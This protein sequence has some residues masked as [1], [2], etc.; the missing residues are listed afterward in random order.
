MTYGVWLTGML[1][2]AAV[3]ATGHVKTT[4]KRVDK[5]MAGIAANVREPLTPEVEAWLRPAL[6]ARDRWTGLVGLAGAMLGGVYLT[7]GEDT[8]A[9]WYVFMVLLGGTAG[10]VVGALVAG[11]RT[12]PNPDSSL[13][14]ASPRDRRLAD[15]VSPRDL[16]VLPWTVPLPF[17]AAALGAAAFFLGGRDLGPI[18]L[19]L[20]AVGAALVAASLVVQRVL[21]SRPRVSSTAA[22]LV[23]QEALLRKTL[24][25]VPRQT[26]CI[27][28]CSAVAGVYDVVSA[29]P[30]FAWWIPEVTLLTLFLGVLVGLF[31]L[32]AGDPEPMSHAQRRARQSALW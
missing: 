4:R 6:A 7:G 2:M 30:A 8:R 22:G 18:A 5:A 20:P 23:W 31:Y 28:W 11:C 32:R 17:V 9:F 14:T 13:R 10:S 26:I 25:A 1:V 12:F 19:S 15:Y 29:V 16:A 24:E 3:A 21:V 27:A